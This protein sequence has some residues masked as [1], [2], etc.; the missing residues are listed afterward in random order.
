MNL[1]PL[2]V[3]IYLFAVVGLSLYG[4]NALLL[5][6]LYLLRRRSVDITPGDASALPSVTVQLPVY[7]ERFVIQRLIDAAAALDYPAERL[8]IQVLDDSTDVTARLAADRIAYHRQH[9]VN[10]THV[11]RADRSGA[12]AGA[13]AAALASAPG[14]FIAVFDADFVPPPDMLRRVMPVFSDPQIGMAQARWGHLNARAS[15]LTR[16]QAMALDGHFVVEQ[17]ARSRA[18]LFFTFNG[19]GGVWRRSAVED[20]GGWQADTLA[21]DLDLS[22]RAQLCGWRF[23]YLPDIIAPAEVPLQLLAFKRQQF[24]WVKGSIQC[25]RKV[26]LHVVRSRNS[27]WRKVQAMLHLGGY[28]VHPL[29]VVLLLAS[30]PTALQGGLGR[31]P[32]GLLSLAGLGP[33]VLYA[34]SQVSAYPDGWKRYLYFPLLMLLGAGIALNNTVAVLEALT[35]RNATQFLRTPKGGASAAVRDYALVSDWT[36]LGEIAL[37]LY[38]LVAAAVAVER[39]PGLAPFLLLFAAGFGYTA[40]M[41][42]AE[43]WQVARRRR[44]WHAAGGGD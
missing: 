13:L 9:G 20:A 5:T 19:S 15:A 35:R 32:L 18:G 7:N 14:E 31:L 27:V 37:A 39:D 17:T 30:L 10:I 1:Q 25:L 33:P 38:A 40:A 23:R 26:G 29:M 11:R 8:S 2:A 3:T 21:E 22:Y 16:A 43:S 6:V 28:L 24:R 41:G 44:S 4:F 36:T 34:V 12:K 42:I